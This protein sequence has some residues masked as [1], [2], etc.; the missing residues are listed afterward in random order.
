MN[1]KF[2]AL[3]ACVPLTIAIA[4]TP[5]T[6]TSTTEVSVQQSLLSLDLSGNADFVAS[7]AL[8][9]ADVLSSFGFADLV[10]EILGNIDADDT[11][12]G[13]DPAPDFAGEWVSN[14]DTLAYK[15]DSSTG[16]ITYCFTGETELVIPETIND[17]TVTAIGD[18]AFEAVTTITSIT[19]PDTLTTIGDN[20]FE[21]CV[22]LVEVVIPDSTSVG[23]NAFPETTT[24]VRQSDQI[25]DVEDATEDTLLGWL[26]EQLGNL[27][28]DVDININVSYDDLINNDVTDWFVDALEDLGI[29]VDYDDLIDQ[30]V[31][32]LLIEEL[33]E[34]EFNWDDFID[35]SLP[36]PDWL[37]PNN[38]PNYGIDQELVSHPVGD[39]SSDDSGID[40]S[41]TD[42]LVGTGDSD[43]TGDD[44]TDDED[45][46]TTDKVH[47]W[48]STLDYKSHDATAKSNIITVIVNGSKAELE[49]YN[50][51]D[52][53]YIGLRNVADLFSS[54]VD[55]DNTTKIVTI[56]SGT[57]SSFV[58]S[59]STAN[60]TVVSKL[61]VSNMLNILIDNRAEQLEVYNISDTNYLGLRDIATLFNCTV[62]YNSATK[63]ITIIS[64]IQP[65]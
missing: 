32:D 44:G 61:A 47:T 51:S 3:A 55:W 8:D 45:D 22:S 4:N 14:G 18:N 49:A 40:N 54:T 5:K 31:G 59:V 53:N 65:R 11:A 46:T 9:A 27:G 15:F 36:M 6:I 48:P 60:Y 58:E 64:N 50:I 43:Y 29:D 26:L 39:D 17:V 21:N 1:K 24:V 2:I 25:V 30:E 7:L 10:D 35:N 12:A 16:T 23:D 41:T 37:K 19:F 28:I 52:T 62:D 38:N 63:E 13:V 57:G 33:E 20:A 34:E 56:T 42:H